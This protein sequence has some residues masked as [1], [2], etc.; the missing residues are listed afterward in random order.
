MF[1]NWFRKPKQITR[2][3]ARAE[4]EGITAFLRPHWARYAASLPPND[5]VPLSA[6]MKM[7]VAQMKGPIGK[8]FPEYKDAP[9]RIFL[10]MLVILALEA[11]RRGFK[12]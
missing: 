8:A 10:N 9:D 6:R 3:Q 1:W 5:T 4:G 11:P 7:F 12:N 2:E